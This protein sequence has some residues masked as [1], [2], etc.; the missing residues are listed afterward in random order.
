[1]NRMRNIYNSNTSETLQPTAFRN[2]QDYQNYLV[3]KHYYLVRNM[4]NYYYSKFRHGY[5]ICLDDLLSVG[6]MAI[7]GAAKTYNPAKGASFATYASKSIER[8]MCKEP[9]NLLPVNMGDAWKTDFTSFSFRKAFDDS[10]FNPDENGKQRYNME[11]QEEYQYCCNW[12][13]EEQELRDRLHAALNML[14]PEDYNLVCAYFGLNEKP[15]KLRQLGERYGVST[16][17]IGKRKERILA[18][19]RAYLVDYY[20]YRMCA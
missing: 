10:V 7:K 17:A 13:E 4:A 3:T 2:T 15:M 6:D 12:D 1:M 8:A 19:L 16:Q 14:A 9:L 20:D 18:Q 5:P 11:P